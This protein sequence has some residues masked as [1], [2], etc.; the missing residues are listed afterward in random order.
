MC[1]VSN[2][3]KVRSARDSRGK[4]THLLSVRVHPEHKKVVTDPFY[5]NIPISQCIY[6]RHND[7]KYNVAL[8]NLIM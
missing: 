5:Y 7:T 1:P 3:K 2:V 4:C 6:D 8:R